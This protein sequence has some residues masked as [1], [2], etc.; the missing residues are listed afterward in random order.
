M[1][2]GSNPAGLTQALVI[3]ISSSLSLPY[4]C[5]AGFSAIHHPAAVAQGG[6]ERRAHSEK[7]SL[8]QLPARRE[9]AEAPDSL[10][11]Q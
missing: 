5:V 8:R 6:R 11:V 1:D 10:P 7:V 4:P 2:F 3:H 9:Q